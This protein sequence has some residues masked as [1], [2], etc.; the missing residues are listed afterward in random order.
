LYRTRRLFLGYLLTFH[1]VTLGWESL[2]GPS[3]CQSVEYKCYFLTGFDFPE[4]LSRIQNGDAL[5]SREEIHGYSAAS[6]SQLGAHRGSSDQ[7]VSLA[8]SFRLVASG[9]WTLGI[10]SSILQICKF[11]FIFLSLLVLLCSRFYFSNMMSFLFFFFVFYR[12]K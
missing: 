8:A 2:S 12:T 9:D 11:G 5:P 7:V 6:F 3:I 1:E 4:V 10:V